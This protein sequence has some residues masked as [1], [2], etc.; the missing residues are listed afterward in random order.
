M[1]Q[2]HIST[3][4]EAAQAAAQALRAALAD[5]SALESLFLLPLIADE[6][7]LADQIG[8]LIAALRDDKGQ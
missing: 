4:R 6:E 7:K 3:A 1:N 2:S 5:S 8:V